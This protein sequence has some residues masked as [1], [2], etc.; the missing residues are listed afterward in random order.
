MMRI[1]GNIILWLMILSFFWLDPLPANADMNNKENQTAQPFQNNMP[2]K[3][4]YV[5]FALGAVYWSNLA[6]IEPWQAGYDRQQFG[7]FKDWGVNFEITYH[8]LATT[9]FERDLWIG[10]DFGLFAIENKGDVY[11]L[12]LTSGEV[13]TGE[14][15]SD[16]LYLTPSLRWFVLGKRGSA[17]L[18]LGAGAGYYSLEF[19]ENFFDEF[20]DGEL[21]EDSTLGGYLSLGLRLPLSKNGPESLAMIL[22]TK[23][24]F[25]DFGE[26]A[27]NTGKIK[28]PIYIFQLGLSF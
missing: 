9:W 22:E 23:V 21:Y 16:G 15:W 11:L 5:S 2:A 1:S 12:S 18:Y 24:H 26:L 10:L 19:T 20:D 3:R 28:G 27:P 13:Y 6:K 8:Y 14:I 25:A 7:Q 4:H 17:R